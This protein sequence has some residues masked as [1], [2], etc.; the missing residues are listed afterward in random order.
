MDTVLGSLNVS[1]DEA[2]VFPAYFT[3]ELPQQ[4]TRTIWRSAL[5]LLERHTPGGLIGVYPRPGLPICFIS[6]RLL[7]RLGYKY[8]ELLEKTKGRALSLIHPRDRQI[9]QN[10]ARTLLDEEIPNDLQFRLLKKDGAAMWVHCADSLCTLPDNSIILIGVC[11]DI[12]GEKKLQHELELGEE[13]DALTGLFNF[14][15]FKLESL[16]AFHEMGDSH[17]SFWFCDLKNFK[18][19]NNIYGHDMGDHI[20]QYLAKIIGERVRPGECCA[21]VS[22][23]HFTVL[24][25]YGD[26]DDLRDYFEEMIAKLAAFNAGLAEKK[27]PVELVCG[28][29]CIESPADLMNVDDMFDRANLAQKSVKPL[30][31]S[32]LAFYTEDMRIQ[33]IQEKEIEADMQVALAMNEFCVYLQPQVDIQHGDRVIGAE[34]LV[35]WNRPGRGLIAPEFFVPIFEKNGFIV[36]LDRYVFIEVCRY[37][38]ECMRADKP[39]Y[40]ISVNVSRISVFQSD[41]VSSYIKIK[42]E[43]RVPDGLLELECTETTMVENVQLLGDIMRQMRGNGFYFALDDFGSG[44]SSLNCL[45]D[46]AVDVLKLD[47]AFFRGELLEKR[48]RAIAQSVI[49]MAKMLDMKTVAEG[50]ETQRLLGILRDMGCDIVQGYL[51]G[52]PM[53]VEDFEAV[54]GRWA[55]HGRGNLAR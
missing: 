35:R 32:R 31:G 23:D 51:F 47:M 37:L 39:L 46:V 29:Y 18:F 25:R 27:F 49:S 12:T 6:S 33:I 44:Y 22:S 30:G 48:D 28:V 20:L 1:E 14:E 9:V 40:K 2:A 24:R 15:R 26:R 7:Q 50:V 4:A 36:D 54:C 42:N 45:K 11:Y 17:Y 13:Y 55:S 53:P 38:S 10:A 5:D 21:R 3:C 41:F 34:A 43:F 16:K 8:E 52:R 19:I